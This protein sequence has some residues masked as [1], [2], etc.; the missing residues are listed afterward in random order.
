MQ[1]QP[2]AVADIRP[3]LLPASLVH[4]ETSFP[5]SN[6]DKHS[7]ESS[8]GGPKPYRMAEANE[9]AMGGF[10]LQDSDQCFRRH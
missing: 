3:P 7:A 4:L 10:S 2:H 6:K 1:T 5:T 9:N 8:R